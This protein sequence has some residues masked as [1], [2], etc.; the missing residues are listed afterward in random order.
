RELARVDSLPYDNRFLSPHDPQY[1]TLLNR[2]VT[3]SLQ[4]S[5]RI[6]TQRNRGRRPPFPLGKGDRGLGKLGDRVLG[7]GLFSN[8]PDCHRLVLAN[9]SPVSVSYPEGWIFSP[10]RDSLS[11]LSP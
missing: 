3:I 8:P 9:I 1:R 6:P 5:S 7:G 2:P 4:S 11:P 10:A